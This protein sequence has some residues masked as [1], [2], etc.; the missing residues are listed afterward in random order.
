VDFSLKQ[1][2]AHQAIVGVLV[3]LT[4]R[5][6]IYIYIPPKNHIATVRTLSRG[7]FFLP[8]SNED[9]GFQTGC[10]TTG[11]MAQSLAWT[12]PTIYLYDFIIYFLRKYHKNG[13]I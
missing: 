1:W 6:Y 10:S 11:T 12:M 5:I 7:D 8:I 4:K 13:K 9:L 3:A 2:E